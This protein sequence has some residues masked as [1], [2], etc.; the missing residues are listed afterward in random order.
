MKKFTKKW[1]YNQLS[2]HKTIYELAAAAVAEGLAPR[3][4][5]GN[6]QTKALYDFEAGRRLEINEK[7]SIYVCPHEKEGN[8]SQAIHYE[9]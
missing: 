4:T 7:R 1:V 8:W 9:V 5:R 6:L 2:T 3:E